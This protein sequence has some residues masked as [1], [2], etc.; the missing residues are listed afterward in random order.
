MRVPPIHEAEGQPDFDACVAAMHRQD[1]K[2]LVDLYSARSSSDRYHLLQGMGHLTKLECPLPAL[3]T[4]EHAIIAAGMCVGWAWRHRGYGRGYS[5]TEDG[6]R[7]MF[8][9]L[10]HAMQIVHEL[11]GD[12]DGVAYAFAIRAEMAL[13]GNRG[14]LN[15][16]ADAASRHAEKNIFVARNHLLFVAPK[17]H[18]SIEEVHEVARDYASAFD[19][20]AWQ[21]L[22]AM[23]HAEARTYALDMSEDEDAIARAR[24]YYGHSKDYVRELSAID[25]AFWAAHE[26]LGRPMGHAETVFGH[27]MLAYLFY[28]RQMSERLRPH[29]EAIGPHLMFQPWVY[30]GLSRP[31]LNDL[32]S[33]A[34]LKRL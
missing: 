18:G 10:E 5:V 21:S 1:W 34:G 22:P 4:P 9:L 31:S 27:N 30:D 13:G 26:R 15:A 32:R 14:T 16:L 33:H 11:Q 8:R 12:A 28:N 23:A 19:H 3:T 2:G 7:N 6:A 17:W 20:P 25:D 29:L 24:V